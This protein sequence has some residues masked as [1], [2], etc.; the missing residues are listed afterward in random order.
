LSRLPETLPVSVTYAEPAYQNW[1]PAASPAAAADALVD[2]RLHQQEESCNQYG[3][4]P[5]Q[6]QD[7]CLSGPGWTYSSLE[8]LQ[9]SGQTDAEH[10]SRERA[11]EL[12]WDGKAPVWGLF[13]PQGLSAYLPTGLSLSSEVRALEGRLWPQERRGQLV[14]HLVQDFTVS[15]DPSLEN[16]WKHLPSAALMGCLRKEVAQAL[17]RSGSGLA[18]R[19]LNPS[20]RWVGAAVDTELAAGELPS[21]WNRVQSGWIPMALWGDFAACLSASARDLGL[22]GDEQGTL[23]TVGLPA[24][25][26][27]ATRPWENWRPPGKPEYWVGA[28]RLHWRGTDFLRRVE[29]VAQLEPGQVVV[30]FTWSEAAPAAEESEVASMGP[31]LETLYTPHPNVIAGR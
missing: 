17:F 7:F 18:R 19:L 13:S 27:T 23:Y 4:Y 20:D 31:D 29:W 30:T 6:Q 2:P 21:L 11:Q 28:G 9:C 10:L 14:L 16:T 15:P 3:V 25:A 24:A 8:G 5:S 26:G 22:S 1:L 12:G